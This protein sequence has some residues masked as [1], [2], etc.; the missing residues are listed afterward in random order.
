MHRLRTLLLPTLLLAP[1][2]P[3]SGAP[4]ADPPAT[5]PAA[6]PP[7]AEPP[8]TFTQDELERQIGERLA[9][10]R[11][12]Y[13]DYEDLKAKAAK[14]EEHEQAQ[15]SELERE[16]Q[17]RTA[18]E[19]KATAATSRAQDALVRAAL[20]SASAGTVDPDAVQ[21]FAL[22][23]GTVTIGDDGQVT[24]ARE[25][26][27]AVLAEKKY[28][29]GTRSPGPGDGG[30]QP[31]PPPPGDLDTRLAD[32][33]GRGDWKTHRQLNAEKFAATLKT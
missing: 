5:P 12:K 13:G 23:K 9:R 16:R 17:A 1:D 19:E 11:S 33:Y 29:V 31:P 15:L 2:P 26:V 20:I 27:E 21:I 18:A 4:P 24:G 30:Q 32:A 6:P 25:A 28:L 10:E 22:Q 8:R 7:P 14:F 3:A